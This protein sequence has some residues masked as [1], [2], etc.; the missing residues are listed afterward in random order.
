MI[1]FSILPFL[2][3]VWWLP[4]GDFCWNFSHQIYFSFAVGT[5][6]VAAW[7]T[8]VFW[9]MFPHPHKCKI[10]ISH[11][12]RRLKSSTICVS[13][14]VQLMLIWK[15]LT[16]QFIISVKISTQRFE[17]SPGWLSECQPEKVLCLFIRYYDIMILD[18]I[19]YEWQEDHPVNIQTIVI[20][21]KPQYTN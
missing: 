20:S 5:K 15:S 11:C 8:A 17:I 4:T 16:I 13:K 3:F 10:K 1:N 2:F 9:E 18:T 12:V 21:L 6:M 14:Y 7:S 19:I